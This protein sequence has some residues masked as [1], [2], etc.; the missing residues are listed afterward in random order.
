[1]TRPVATVASPATEPFESL[2]ARIRACRVCEQYLPHG[3]RPVLQAHPDARL[4][5]V[6]QAPGRKVHDTGI[7]FN[8]KSGD[9]LRDWLGIDKQSFYDPHRVAIVPMGFCYPGKG[10]SGD[11]PPRPECAPLW[12]PLLMPRLVNVRLTLA[13]GGYAIRGMLGSARKSTLTETCEAWRA[14]FDGGVLP[15]PHPSPRN[16]AWFQRHPWFET[17]TLPVLK[18]RVRKLLRD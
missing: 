11:L 8:D 4:L 5:I 7:P 16:T 14:Y 3:C 12:H 15:L 2:M 6:S 1:M 10:A 18:K 13:I 17:D 9:K